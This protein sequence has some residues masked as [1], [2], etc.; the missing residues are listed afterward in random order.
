MSQQLLDL[1]TGP[2]SDDG[3]PGRVGGQKINENFTELYARGIQYTSVTTPTFTILGADLVVGHNIY[4][5]YYDGVVNIQLPANIDSN[6]LVVIKDEYGSAS[7]NNILLSV[8]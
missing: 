1:G 5:V 2:D 7:I 8:A 3:D 6:K 4:G